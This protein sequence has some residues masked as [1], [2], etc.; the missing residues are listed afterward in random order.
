MSAHKFTYISLFSCAGVG[1]F[2]FLQE[3]F[4]CIATVE[5]L[6]RR[7]NVQR[8]NNKCRYE[9]GY[10][11]GDMTLQETH[12]RI[13]QEIELYRQKQ[14]LKTVDVVVATPPCQG[15]SVANH[16]KGDELGR[17]SLVV[18]SIKCILDIQPN[19][20]VFENVPAFCKAICTDID[21]V[22]RPIKDAIELNLGS[23]Y[24]IVYQVLNFKDF[25]NASSRTRTLVIGVNRSIVNVSPYDILPTK[26]AEHSLRDVI[27]NLPSLKTMGSIDEHDFY[28]GFRNYAPHMLPW[29]EN[30]KEGQSAFENT[31]PQRIPHTIKDGKVV[32]NKAKQ[33]DKYRRQLWDKVAPCV[34]TR[35]DILA[36]QNTVHPSDNRVFSIRELMLMMSIPYS[37]KWLPQSLE[38]LN[39]LS[40]EQK[41]ALLKKEE[42]N[43]RQCIG[44]AVPTI[45][46]RQI[47]NNIKTSLMNSYVSDKDIKGL[48]ASHN[49]TD[50]KQ[51]QN[52]VRHVLDK[53]HLSPASKSFIEAPNHHESS[54]D[55]AS[56]EIVDFGTS[57]LLPL[58]LMMLGHEQQDLSVDAIAQAKPQAQQKVSGTFPLA[59]LEDDNKNTANAFALPSWAEE[60]N[61]NL[62]SRI[63][64]LANSERQKTAA[65]YTRQDI[66]FEM[67]KALPDFAKE[68]HLRILEPSV[69][70]GN[71]LPALIAKYGSHK[72][73]E[74]DVVDIDGD[75]L[76]LL[77]LLG[78][79]LHIPNNFRINIINDDFLLHN[80]T[81]H[82]HLVIGNPPFKKLCG[83]VVLLDRYKSQ[84]SN[85]QTNNICAFFL[86]KAMTLA[87]VVA[88][89]VPKSII[90]APEF[91]QTRHVIEQHSVSHI[92]D[93]GELAFKGVKIETIGLI[94]HSEETPSQ[95]SVVS[96]ITNSTTTKLQKYIMDHQFPY[97]LLY[98]DSKF[99]DVASSMKFAI[100]K[101]FRDRSI[102]KAQ[103]EPYGKY[104]VLKSRNIGNNTIIDVPN[105]DSYMDDISGLKVADFLNR[106]SCVLVPNLTYNPRACFLPQNAIADGSVAI[107]EL[108]SPVSINED[109][110]A[111][112]ATD[113]FKDFYKVARNLGT[114]SLNIDNNAVFFFGKRVR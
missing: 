43:I 60:S 87:S 79:L 20:F 67:I 74:V 3:G 108:T 8:Y 111:F 68:E 103:T 101:A 38:E 39:K 55:V 57:D 11:C 51:A 2:G 88:L 28:H 64:E 69:G 44:E 78:P 10:I 102:T 26:Q 31:D 46:M 83:D 32:F 27:G 104:R 112:Y 17:N 22:N 107:L 105:Y 91:N 81:Q 73:V 114:R 15:M 35:N 61:F 7:L 98:R 12:D 45:I 56:N 36:S 53:Q 1:C 94:I 5:L 23:D 85:K 4:D 65:F 54:L 50:S 97:W 58:E 89:I 41:T 42:L 106:T 66:C 19:F 21:G 80:F 52:F 72:L 33:G 92:I 86:E 29:I 6:E 113:T 9:S 76:E 95:T 84:S 70:L 13:A 75:S 47:A 62:L 96:Y 77:Q 40:F 82:Y 99:D 25:G 24:H 109:D 63:M 90:N 110:L 59:A 48:I 71:F 16:K 93:F 18:E 34:H 14:G 49:L 37:F 30:L 100:F